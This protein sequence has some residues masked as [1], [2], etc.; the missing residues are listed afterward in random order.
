MQQ[1]GHCPW[2]WKL[3]SSGRGLWLATGIFSLLKVDSKQW[4]RQS[5]IAMPCHAQCLQLIR[6]MGP[7]HAA[8]DALN[9]YG[10]THHCLSRPLQ[11]WIDWAI[12]ACN[13]QG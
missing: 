6:L 10:V 3:K 13:L 12:S 5:C 2:L 11:I 4:R 1:A 7:G 8:S 9:V